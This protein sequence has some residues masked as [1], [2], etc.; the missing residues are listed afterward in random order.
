MW[1]PD[2]GLALRVCPC[3]VRMFEF[4]APPEQAS[5]AR[6]GIRA[7][8]LFLHLASWTIVYTALFIIQDRC[9]AKGRGWRR[10]ATAAA[11]QQERQAQGQER[12]PWGPRPSDRRRQTWRVRA[13]V[14]RGGGRRRGGTRT[15]AHS[16]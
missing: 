12:Q 4:F 7:V 9:K 3:S 2:L 1:V 11:R 5:L 16:L 15:D 10:E 13:G 14:R 6:E 8:D